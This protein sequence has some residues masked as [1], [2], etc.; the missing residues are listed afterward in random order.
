[1]QLNIFSSETLQ[2]GASL[3]VN[4]VLTYFQL[5]PFFVL[6]RY[7]Y[8]S[9]TQKQMHLVCAESHAVNVVF[10]SLCNHTKRHFL[11]I[12]VENMLVFG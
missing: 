4:N 10:S 12:H 7:G 9:S 11:P 3:F 1:M 6:I 2:T 8:V 5:W